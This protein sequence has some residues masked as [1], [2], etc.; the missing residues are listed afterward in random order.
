MALRGIPPVAT[1]SME[2]MKKHVSLEI[3][4]EQL[5]N[6]RDT[7]GMWNLITTPS[8]AGPDDVNGWVLAPY[9]APLARHVQVSPTGW[10]QSI[11]DL[12][13]SFSSLIKLVGENV[14]LADLKNQ[15]DLNGKSAKKGDV[16]VKDG[17]LRICV[18]LNADG[19]SFMV[20]PSNV[21]ST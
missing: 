21:H 19:R 3:T 11:G 18:T 15:H 12:D 9:A 1:F 13:E 14:K 16:F 4:F 20:N 10:F 17:K 7:T 5:D 8:L 2:N 6:K